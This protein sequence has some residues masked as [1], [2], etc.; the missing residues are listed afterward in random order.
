MKQQWVQ[1]LNKEKKKSEEP[2]LVKVADASK[3]TDWKKKKV[4]KWRTYIEASAR[5]KK[6]RSSRNRSSAWSWLADDDQ[7]SLIAEAAQVWMA[8]GCRAD[9]VSWRFTWWRPA[10]AQAQCRSEGQLY[11]N[12]TRKNDSFR[13]WTADLRYWHANLKTSVGFVSVGLSEQWTTAL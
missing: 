2:C 8:A 5:T 11:P 7:V 1:I 9:W 13:W 4:I 12:P 3:L 10:G 6:S